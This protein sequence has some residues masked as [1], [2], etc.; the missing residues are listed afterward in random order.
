MSEAPV[1]SIFY[2][3]SR[4]EFV[5]NNMVSMLLMVAMALAGVESPEEP[6]YTAPVVTPPVPDAYVYAEACGLSRLAR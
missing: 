5:D 6:A 4:K 2:A 1:V 3:C